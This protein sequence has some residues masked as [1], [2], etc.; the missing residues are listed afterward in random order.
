MGNEILLLIKKINKV[1]QIFVMETIKMSIDLQGK[2]NLL[3]AEQAIAELSS[4]AKAGLSQDE[5]EKR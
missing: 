1:R 2:F 4:N 3:P 5:A